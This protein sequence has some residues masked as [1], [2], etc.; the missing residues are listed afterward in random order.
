MKLTK[1]LKILS[2]AMLFWSFFPLLV[3]ADVAIFWE[4]STGAAAVQ[5]LA[6]TAS[7]FLGYGISALSEHICPKGTRGVRLFLFNLL[8]YGGLLAPAAA[9]LFLFAAPS[10]VFPLPVLSAAPAALVMTIVYFMGQS[11]YFKPYYDVLKFPFVVL[12]IIGG[13]ALAVSAWVLGKEDVAVSYPID[14][15][16]VVFLIFISVYAIAKSQGT[17]DFVMDRRGHKMSALP[18]NIRNYNLLLV[19]VLLLL[20]VLAFVFREPIGAFLIL[21]KDGVL[22]LV[23]CLIALFFWLMSLFYSQSGEESSKGG[24]GEMDLSQLDQGNGSI[25]DFTILILILVVAG[26]IIFNWKRIIAGF[27]KLAKGMRSLGRKLFWGRKEA[28]GRKDEGGDYIDEEESLTEEEAARDSG[29][30]G[31]KAWRKSYRA[32]RKLEDSEGK[33]RAGYRLMVEWLNLKG[34]PVQPSDTTLEILQKSQEKLADADAGSVTDE[35]NGIRYGEKDADLE[36]MHCLAETLKRLEADARPA[37]GE[38]KA[39]RRAAAR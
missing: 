20:L 38:K 5:L 17:L 11:L 27:R 23:K 8:R 19:C 9:G 10:R 35:Y 7:G 18:S 28:Y 15:V 12:Q 13:V 1:T 26:L 16:V 25:P 4:F 6:V 21:L 31:W 30:C 14:L 36:K 2:V 39:Q 34:V 37:K 33:L 24:T 3:T 29:L 32:F 22:F